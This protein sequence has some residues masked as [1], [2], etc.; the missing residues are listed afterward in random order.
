MCPHQIRSYL[1]LVSTNDHTAEATTARHSADLA[2]I[3]QYEIRML[4]RLGSRWASWFDGLILTNEDDGTTVIRGPV[5]DQA[6]LHGL[7]Q[8]LRDLGIPLLSLTRLPP[9]A[10]IEQ[11][12]LPHH[13]DRHDQPGAPS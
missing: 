13:Q 8:Q 10:A 5:V 9:G 4:G 6:A 3:P 7:L 11:P 1:H 12:D 2:R